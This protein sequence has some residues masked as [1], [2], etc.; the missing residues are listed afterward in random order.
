MNRAEKQQE[1]AQLKEML[2]SVQTL[3]LAD[4]RGLTVEESNELRREFRS[5]GCQYRVI[6]NTLLKRALEG[7]PL[8]EMNDLLVGPTAMAFS[9]EEPL[10]P[11]K[12]L[13]KFAKKF[14]PLEIKGAFFEGI[15]TP[16]E[17]VDISKMPG[18]DELR[19]KLLQTMLA[20]PQNMLRLLLAAPQRFLMVLQARGRKIEQE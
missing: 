8:E 17:V 4:Y 19:S 1:V 15:R 12:V 6:K 18:K 20:A 13:V 14:K 7:T 5:S 11:A 10:Q 2:T 9:T 3:F 16:Q